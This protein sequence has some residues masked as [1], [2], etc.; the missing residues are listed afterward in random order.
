MSKLKDPNYIKSIQD[1]MNVAF[2]GN[3]GEMLMDFLESTCCWYQ[4]T[5]VPG[6]PQMTQVNDG[7]R[8]V[9][10][11]IKTFMKLTP[12]Q[13]VALVNQREGE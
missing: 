7:K 12:E 6:D 13:I 1:C 5:L 2:T 8:Q 3:N 9:L 10:S 11:T 4:S